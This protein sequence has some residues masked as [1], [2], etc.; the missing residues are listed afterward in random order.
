M[1]FIHHTH[2][3]FVYIDLAHKE[4]SNSYICRYLQPDACSYKFQTSEEN[5]KKTGL[6]ILEK[7][8]VSCQ[9]YM[10]HNTNTASHVC[11]VS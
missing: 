8:T 4:H 2:S 5:N 1:M 10:M 11:P 9:R 3:H 6:K 7:P